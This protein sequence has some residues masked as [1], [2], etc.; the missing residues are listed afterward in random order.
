MESSGNDMLQSNI[1]IA[2]EALCAQYFFFRFERIETRIVQIL[3]G[4]LR[5]I[6]EKAIKISYLKLDS[7]TR[8]GRSPPLFDSFLSDL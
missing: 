7:W 3:L 4:L 8:L 5:R 1:K 6:I 2:K